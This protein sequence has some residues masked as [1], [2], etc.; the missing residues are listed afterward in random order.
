[1]ETSFESNTFENTQPDH[2]KIFNEICGKLN[3]LSK[4]EDSKLSKEKVMQLEKMQNQMKNFQ[5]DLMN[6]HEEMKIKIE[7]LEKM[8]VSNSDLSSK[9]QELTDLLNQERSHNSKLSSDLARSLD[10]SLKLQL[11]IQEIKARA[12]QSHTEEKR[13]YLE[14]CENLQLGF[15]KEKMNL[16]ETNEELLLDLK[17]KEAQ[18]EELT[19]KINELESSMGELACTSDEQNQ[20]IQHLMK[21]AENK[22][23]ELKIALDK[24]TSD[25]DNN[26]G[27]LT[28]MTQQVDILKQENY[29][30]KDYINKMTMYQ[31]QML[32]MQKQNIQSTNYST[33]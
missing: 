8:T 18:I 27:H 22:I 24:Q 7:A 33:K 29:A 12:I 3:E 26:Q 14:N 4:A 1:M 2:E 15:Q 13:Q 30:L 31:Q 32:N 5:L 19:Q 11:E 9:V 25:N 21:T 17:N 20:T 10:L 16:L 23:V 6:N 28:K